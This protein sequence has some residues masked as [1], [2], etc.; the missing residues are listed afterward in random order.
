MTIEVVEK[1]RKEK[2]EKKTKAAAE[3]VHDGGVEQATEKEK[4]HEVNGE[5][6]K[7]DKDSEEAKNERKRRKKEEKERKRKE[8]QAEDELPDTSGEMQ[9]DSADAAA[10]EKAE[11][12]QKKKDKKA[13]KD[14]RKDVVAAEASEPSNGE[15]SAAAQPPKDKK[16]KRK[17]TDDVDAEP[18]PKKSK[19]EKTAT[20]S[21]TSTVTPPTE[22]EISSY[23]TSNGVTLST[24]ITPVLSFRALPLPVALYEAV[25]KLGF[26]KPTPVQACTWPALLEGRDAVG[27]AETGSGKTLAFG[28]PALARLISTPSSSKKA[29]VR[30]LVLAPTRELALQ[31]HDTLSTLLASIPAPAPQ[32]TCIALFGGVPK[33]PQVAQLRSADTQI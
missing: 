19:K 22:D 11:K 5:G 30:V 26:D 7:E 14:K 32:I 8:A 27:I 13:K 15:A 1:K 18:S 25:Q 29:C 31:T 9:I 33:P 28:I 16:K 12:K 24:P 20:T 17:H 21:S 23:L 2:K 4:N 10:A 3:V 6:G